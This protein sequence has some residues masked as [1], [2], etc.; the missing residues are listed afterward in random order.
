MTITLVL[1]S[2]PTFAADWILDSNTSQLNFISI[3]KG[4]IAEVHQFKSLQGQYTEQGK[5]KVTIDLASV[6]TQNPVRDE[7]MKEHLFEVDSC[8][9][10]ILSATVDTEI[11]DAIAEGAS[12]QLTV[13]AT[14]QLH[15]DTQP[16]KIDVII[17]RLVGAKLSVVSAKPVVINAADFSLIKGVDKLMALAKLPSISQA[18][19]ITFY[20]TFNLKRD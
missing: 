11:I 20:L 9:S 13:D 17:T 3:K 2:V 8:A 7:R 4:N 15:G 16:L 12:E 5:L 1:F 19:P 6:D 10:A 14:L 18:V